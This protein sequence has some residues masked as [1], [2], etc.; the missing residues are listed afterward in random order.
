MMKAMKMKM[1]K[2]MFT[3][4]CGSDMIEKTFTTRVNDMK[5]Q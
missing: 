2:M 5:A 4:S 1:K 3:K